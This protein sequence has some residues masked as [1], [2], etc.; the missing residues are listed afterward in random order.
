MTHL[1][2]TE[3]LLRIY[4]C[5]YALSHISPLA[6]YEA[7]FPVQAIKSRFR[8]FWRTSMGFIRVL[9][10]FS[11]VILVYTSLV[12]AVIALGTMSWPV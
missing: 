3:S 7:N 5:I 4:V 6:V 10:H 8:R 2:F 1:H 12:K 9:F 11:V